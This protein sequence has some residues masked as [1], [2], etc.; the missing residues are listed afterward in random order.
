LRRACSAWS[1]GTAIRTPPSAPAMYQRCWTWN[2]STTHVGI[3]FASSSE[4][5]TSASWRELYDA[6]IATSSAIGTGGLRLPDRSRQPP[7]HLRRRPHP[8][9]QRHLGVGPDQVVAG[10][11]EAWGAVGAG[12]ERGEV[13]EVAGVELREHGVPAV[14]GGGDRLEA[15][16][17]GARE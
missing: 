6:T 11:G 12:G 8:R 10:E 1:R 14:D 2:A 4:R 13:S 9:R 5:A 16:D 15:A 17:R 7:P 3:A